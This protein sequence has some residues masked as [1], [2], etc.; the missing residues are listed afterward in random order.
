MK[1]RIF[2]LMAIVAAMITFTACDPE[3]ESVTEFSALPVAAQ[4]TVTTHF[5]K[6]QIMLIIFDKELFDKE[7]TVTFYDGTIIE[8]DKNGAWENIESYVE[9]VPMSIIPE[10][11]AAYLTTNY[12]TQKVTE[13]DKETNGYDVTL[14]SKIELTFDLSGTLVGVDVE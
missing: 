7:Y 3:S 9:G 13:L 6:E 8:F 14:E 4:T 5:D 11:I 10:K 1:R 12:A 2:A